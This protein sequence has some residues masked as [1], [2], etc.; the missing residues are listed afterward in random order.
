MVHDIEYCYAECRYPERRNLLISM[1]TVVMLSVVMLNVVAPQSLSAKLKL[2]IGYKECYK[3]FFKG[4]N[5][6]SSIR[7]KKVFS[8]E[9]NI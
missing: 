7:H 6:N 5:I 8:A 3:S 2:L 1:H 4:L 9:S